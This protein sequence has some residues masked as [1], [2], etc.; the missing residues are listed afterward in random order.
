MT[1]NVI[2]FGEIFY[3]MVMGFIG[4]FL[5][6]IINA[7]S[8]GDLKTFSS[9]KRLVLGP[10]SGFIYSLLYSEYNFPN[11]LMAIASGWLGTDFILKIMEKFNPAE[12]QPEKPET[13]ET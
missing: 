12:D 1:S 7:D 6:V 13:P 11:S 2:D 8:L 9:L 5:H 10:C 4:G 3:F